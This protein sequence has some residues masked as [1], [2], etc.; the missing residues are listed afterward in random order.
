VASAYLR[1]N[2]A[3]Q[4]LL[5]TYNAALKEDTRKRQRTRP[6]LR[7]LRVDSFHSFVKRIDGHAGMPGRI[8]MEMAR[9]PDPND[10]I[11]HLVLIDECQDMTATFYA[12]VCNRVLLRHPDASLVIVGDP[13]QALYEYLGADVRYLTLAPHLFVD[14]DRWS[15]HALTVSQRITPPMARLLSEAMLHHTGALTSAARTPPF[16]PV[17]YVVAK[18][19]ARVAAHIARTYL[20]RG[21]P[22]SD[23]LVLAASV[24][25]TRGPARRMQLHMAE[26]HLHFSDDHLRP[27]GGT[28]GRAKV[29]R[30]KLRIQTMAS[31]KGTE[32]PIVIVLGFDGSYN[33]F[34]DRKSDPKICSNAL[35]VAASRS[36]RELILI[37]DDNAG[38]LPCLDRTAM[39]RLHQSG[40][41]A[42]HHSKLARDTWSPHWEVATLVSDDIWSHVCPMAIIEPPSTSA[43]TADIAQLSIGVTQLLQSV[44]EEALAFACRHIAIHPI[45]PMP[46]TDVTMPQ[47]TH[48][49]RCHDTRIED[50][51]HL[52]GMAATPCF[53]L[54]Q[55]IP[56]Q[57]HS[58]TRQVAEWLCMEE[59]G[60]DR[61]LQPFAQTS[62]RDDRQRIFRTLLRAGAQPI[63]AQLA[64]PFPYAWNQLSAGEREPV[65]LAP[66]D[67]ASQR[68]LLSHLLIALDAFLSCNYQRLR[69]IPQDATMLSTEEE[70]T[71]LADRIRAALPT[72]GSV[73]FEVPIHR[74]THNGTVQL[75][76]RGSADAY[77]EESGS[78]FEFKLGKVSEVDDHGREHINPLYVAQVAIYQW[79][80]K[81]QRAQLIHLPSGKRWSV[82]ASE[83]VTQQLLLD[84]ME[85][86][87]G[88]RYCAIRGRWVEAHEPNTEHDFIERNRLHV[89]RLQIVIEKVPQADVVAART[90]LVSVAVETRGRGGPQAPLVAFAYSRWMWDDDVASYVC[91]LQRE[92]RFEMPPQEPPTFNGYEPKECNDV[93]ETLDAV[94]AAWREAS[95]GAARVASNARYYKD[96][97]DHNALGSEAD[98]EEEGAH[99]LYC[100]K[101]K[102]GQAKMADWVAEWMASHPAPP[103]PLGDGKRALSRALQCAWAFIHS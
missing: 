12:I 48:E 1:A 88:K 8:A 74:N 97:L 18:D 36:Q 55:H 64:T 43:E 79:M 68:H 14:T 2:P 42:L 11:Y 80:Q 40:A 53:E 87:A 65:P 39:D 98:D 20:D 70:C 91:V 49:L 46:P 63:F 32:A 101:S 23:I 60:H 103:L 100:L 59:E 102:L 52:V 92:H 82:E 33:T 75:Q 58:L 96:V 69:H 76:L 19:V 28:S 22:A 78:L 6:E 71:W 99:P 62:T 45:I 67:A 83:A 86:R 47:W 15:V 3:H 61:L 9:H 85:L 72:R 5:L 25:S 10:A 29:T 24:R 35:Y 89:E 31:S 57:Q 16:A 54:S 73:Q 81:A 7:N 51:F 26:Q 37:Q 90:P 41:L 44:S 38:A 4:A 27:G 17:R 93:C 84:I 50:V 94:R 95:A 34:F 66:A 56:W 21:V 13:R 77:V 30:G